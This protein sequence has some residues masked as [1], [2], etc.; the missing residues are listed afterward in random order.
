MAL[1]PAIVALSGWHKVAGCR[2]T[3]AKKDC[4]ELWVA[5]FGFLAVFAGTFLEGETILLAAG[6][7]AHGGQ[8]PLQ[9][10]ITA[11]FLGSWSGHLAW[12][13][14]G[15]LRGRT[16][17]QKRPQ[18]LGAFARAENLIDRFG[19]LAI[20]ITQYLYGMRLAAAV[21]F[22]ISRMAFPRFALVQAVNCL[23][24]SLAVATL[25]YVFG[26]A[27]WRFLGHVAH[28]EKVGA[29]IVLFAGTLAVSLR[30][31]RRRW[32]GE[33]RGEL[34]AEGEQHDARP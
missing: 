11:A 5:R 21:A 31:A 30:Y 13:A 4:M 20:F 17:L 22:G 6:I 14:V 8:L 2:E 25:G 19:L 7:L 33:A 24:W 9:M 15:R 26:E 29:A 1:A 28:Y 32:R 16:S 23:I 34:A 12:F 18:L 10:V 27:A 3:L